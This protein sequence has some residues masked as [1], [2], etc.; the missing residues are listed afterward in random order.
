MSENNQMTDQIFT[1][2]DK[3]GA[4]LE[5]TVDLSQDVAP[6]MTATLAKIKQ[7]A[8][9]KQGD[10]EAQ[11]ELF[12]IATNY[13]PKTI[14]SYCGL[15][16]EYR[17][18]RIVKADKTARQ[19]LIESLKIFKKQVF[20]LEKQF[21]SAIENQIKVESS[22]IHEK[23]AS[24]LELATELDKVGDDG[25]VN[26]FDFSQYKDSTHYKDI[27]FKRELSQEEV[28]AKARSEKNNERIAYVGNKIQSVSKSVFNSS[29]NILTV[30]GKGLGLFLVGIL[31]IFS[32][33][34]GVILFLTALVGIITM[35][36]R[37]QRD[38]NMVEQVV[39]TSAD[40]HSIM[41]INIIPSSEF[42][43]FVN[44]KT[45][46]LID[47]SS[48]RKER[49]HVTYDSKK[50]HISMQVDDVDKDLCMDLI[51]KKEDKFDSVFIHVNGMSLPQDNAVSEHKIFINENHTL[52]HLKE[53]NKLTL[54]FDNQKIYNFV[55]GNISLTSAE[56]A[57]KIA[58]LE[59]ELATFE[60][61]S[62]EPSNARY[63]A[64]Y[65]ERV[66]KVKD[67]LTKAKNIKVVEH[68]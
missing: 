60:E 64:Y 35:I 7:L 56:K 27:T 17:N 44:A 68:N 52:C 24:Q 33:L 39:K 18:T 50:Q 9:A 37:S 67:A 30:V 55:K 36:V 31:K 25:F 48:Y 8:I 53:G 11:Y 43:A 6:F 47:D 41:G 29:V 5:S 14:D 23:Y 62:K 16:I 66:D 65:S 32:E 2:I 19:L 3:I 59:K 10:Y 42:A 38:D 15:P 57:T 21:Y 40:I 45:K 51:D 12:Q 26:Q 22:F 46:E 61:I 49:V 34:F 58:N 20:D 4:V 54:D 28:Q 13:L 1:D 63:P